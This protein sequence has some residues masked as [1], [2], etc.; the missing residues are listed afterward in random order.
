G[1]V[2][3]GVRLVGLAQDH[4]LV[5]AQLLRSDGTAETVR[6]PWLVGCDGAFSTVRTGLGVGFEGEDYGQV[7]LQGDVRVQWP[8]PVRDDEAVAFFS[9][10]GALAAVPLRRGDW[11]RLMALQPQGSDVE[12]TLENLQALLAARGPAG[13][14][15]GEADWVAGFPIR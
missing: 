3:R 14:R 1:V 15:L 8:E 2:E 13:A 9:P 6:A 4:E 5:T 12:P 7:L 11:W 10:A